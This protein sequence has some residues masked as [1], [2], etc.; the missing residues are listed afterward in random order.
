MAELSDFYGGGG[1]ENAIDYRLPDLPTPPPAQYKTSAGV[2]LQGILDKDPVSRMI[3]K[4]FGFGQKK[5]RVN[6]TQSAINKYN[7]FIQAEYEAQQRFQPFENALERQS[8][9][10]TSA[11]YEDI[12]GP[13]ANR[14]HARANAES[15]FADLQDYTKL[16]SEFT[17]A[18]TAAAE[19]DP[20][21][22]GLRRS[23]MEDVALGS[24][25]DPIEL[26]KAQ[27]LARMN[28]TGG[29]GQ[30]SENDMM[31]EALALLT[32]GDQLRG[33]RMQRATSVLQ[34]TGGTG[35]DSFLGITGRPSAAPGFAQNAFGQSM[36]ESQYSGVPKGY[37]TD[38]LNQYQANKTNAANNKSALIGAG[39]GAIGSIGG[40]AMKMT[41]WVAREVFG[42]DNPKWLQ[43]RNWLLLDGP[44]WFMRLYVMHGPAWA[45]WLHEHPWAKP[46]VR[47]WMESRIRAFLKR[48]NVNRN[49]AYEL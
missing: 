49:A 21:V 29:F 36:Q 7:S 13:S 20:L 15:R 39:I 3:N 31:R 9:R 30:G 35:V 5:R 42:A 24:D 45:A 40:G 12:L 23:A 1:Q 17:R 47:L 34:G 37:A 10:N 41:C 32:H 19:A 38:L 43:F 25:M 11:L 44:V 8:A 18:H 22:A 46:P 2:P 27:Q 28:R 4:I 26:R 33:S 16:G 6:K 14:L 48:R